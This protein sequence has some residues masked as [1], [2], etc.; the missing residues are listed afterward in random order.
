MRQNLGIK[1]RN[2][3]LVIAM[4]KYLACSAAR[5]TWLFCGLENLEPFLLEGPLIVAVWHEFLALCP[6]LLPRVARAGGKHLS[7]AYTLVSS[8]RDGVV[9]SRIADRFGVTP[10]Y[11]S[12]TRGGVHALRRLAVVFEKKSL[13]LVAPDGPR[14]PRRSSDEGLTSAGFSNAPVVTLGLHNCPPIRLSSWDR[15][16]LPRPWTKGTICSGPVM[17]FEPVARSYSRSA[18]VLGLLMTSSGGHSK[19]ARH[20]CLSD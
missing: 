17:V 2:Y 18:L 20:V 14:G 15:L 4:H 6:A 9:A 7:K 3:Y 19:V 8:H 5:S 10:I 12:S 11:G 1:V 16:L 13:V